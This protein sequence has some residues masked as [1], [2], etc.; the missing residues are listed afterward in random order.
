MRVAS[1]NRCAQH[2]KFFRCPFA[3]DLPV[4]KTA[5]AE[6]TNEVFEAGIFLSKC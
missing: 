1:K 5:K 6:K 4:P 3:F 2:S